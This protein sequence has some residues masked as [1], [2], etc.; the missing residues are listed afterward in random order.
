MNFKRVV[1][2]VGSALVAPDGKGCSGKYLL[3]IARFI[4]QCHEQGKDVILVSSGSVAAGRQ[5]IA[6]GSANPSIASKQA[7]AGYT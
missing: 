4:S 6:H 3:A 2:K 1:I 5:L 7:M